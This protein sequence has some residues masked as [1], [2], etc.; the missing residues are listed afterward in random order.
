MSLSSEF[1]GGISSNVPGWECTDIK[2]TCI[3]L[4]VVAQ[5]FGALYHVLKVADS[6]TLGHVSRFWV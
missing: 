6:I 4:A 5:L 1:S 3:A 2:T